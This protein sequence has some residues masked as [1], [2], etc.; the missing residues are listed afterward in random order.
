ML[1][2]SHMA[3]MLLGCYLQDPTLTL[4]EKYK[5]DASEFQILFHQ[6][7]YAICYNCATEGYKSLSIM[8][9]EKRL[10]PYK[11]QYQC[12][13]DNNGAEYIE[14]V[15]EL[16]DISNFEVY[17][18]EFRKF[19]CLQAYKD[20]GFNIDEFYDETKSEESQLENLNK[21][22]IEEIINHFEGLQV[23]VKRRFTNNGVKEEYLAGSDFIYSKE[24]Y[25][26]SPLIGNSFQSPYL[27]GI[28]RGMY[29]FLIRGAKSGGGKAQPIDTI[30]PT[31]NGNKR[32]GDI[33]VGDY[34]YDRMGNP[35]KVLGTYP[36][37]MLDCY[38]VTLSDGRQTQCNDEHLWSF[39][40]VYSHNKD[41]RQKLVTKT[42]KEISN[43]SNTVYIPTNCGIEMDKISYDI[44]P[45]VIGAFLGDGCCREKTLTL[46]SKDETLVANV[47]YLLN[48]TYKKN[49]EKNYNWQFINPE[50]GATNNARS[51]CKFI[52]TTHL[53]NKYQNELCCYSYEKRIPT[54]YKYGSIEQRFSLIQGMMDT[55]G[56]ISVDNNRYNMSYSTTSLELANDFMDVLR[57]LGYNCSIR[58]DLREN[59][60]TCYDVNILVPNEEKYK[61]FRLDRKLQIANDAKIFTK[62]R[63]YDRIGIKNIKKENYQK[64]M[65]CIY[66]DNEEHL[67]LT[68]DYIVTHNTVLS[69]GDLCKT[70]AKMYYD[71]EVGDFVVNKSRKGNALLIN[72]EL[73][74]RDELDPMII[75]WI[76]GVPRNHIID[77]KY[78]EG[79]EDRVDRAYEILIDSGLYIVDD[80]E[81]TT[82]SLITTIKDYALNKGVKTIC[83]DYIQNNGFVAKELSSETKVPQRED[84][85]LL[86]L[87]D[88]LKQVQ[89]ECG[90]SLISAV[91]TNGQEDSMEFPTEC[92]LAGGK[93]QVRKT[94]GTM[95]M[96]P[97]TKK[98]LAQLEVAI[99]KWNTKNCGSFR[100]KLQP[101]NVVHIIKGRGSKY[102][103]N[104]KVFQ[105][106]DLSTAR[107]YDMFCTDKYNNPIDVDRLVIE[108]EEE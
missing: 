82:K 64:E 46:S 68:N 84:M 17:Y 40:N 52:Q 24:R 104:I 37:G 96:L 15:T 11:S 95:I 48:A 55:D 7:I 70:T 89:R 35:T 103:K 21:Y 26:E 99:T 3:D 53:F 14:T 25:K 85:A 28:F 77:A 74:L 32:L 71:Y 33:K 47:A 60:R 23:D 27:N 86:A 18:K 8:D 58:K 91:Q 65:M 57:S 106:I 10:E 97:P 100:E 36:Q 9:F 45:Y 98:E 94:D 38:T 93:S 4:N 54:E 29:G 69:V 107:S 59:R 90:V 49:S 56:N 75:A 19:S 44:D 30:I 61:F 16:T 105:Y 39:Y 81:F 72:T 80:P 5:I 34:V 78:E 51:D 102:P 67:Y 1:Y 79:E 6:I 13:L 83:F 12:Y 50:Y 22:T 108:Y 31:P 76:S 88:R 62:K 92:C 42:L 66:V 2:S 87:T 20:I 41:Y 101:N 63:H 73:D 43:L